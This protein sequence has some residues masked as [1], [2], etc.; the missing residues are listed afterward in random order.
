MDFTRE[1]GHQP[2]GFLR[3]A[4]IASE[5]IRSGNLATVALLDVKIAFVGDIVGEPGRR[6]VQHLVPRLRKERGVNCVIANGEN[7][8]GGAG[9][10][11]ETAAEIFSSGVDVI[12]TGDHVWDQKETA[13]FIQHEARLLRPCNYPSGTPGNGSIA[14]RLEDG[15][16]VGV[17]NLQ[18]LTFMPDLGDPFEVI[19]EE[20]RRL[21]H[22]TSILIIDFHAEATSEK[23]ALGR[24]LDGKA[25]AVLGTHTHVQTADE[26]IFPGGTAF[27]CDVG[28]T[29]P[30]DSVIGRE[31]EPVI[32]RFR[33]R[34]PQ[35]FGVARG[36]V[37]MQGV[38]LEVDPES[39]RTV[40][41]ERFSIPL[42]S[43]EA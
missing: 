43:A 23:I 19:E 7:S 22:Y 32:R 15:R 13:S 42:D 17:V 4:T 12:T 3:S 31:I 38:L 36:N 16:V 29:G 37:Q 26:R 27:L 6:A 40:S 11:Q 21:R 41:I 30:H 5:R 24:F 35:R 39:G 18:G 33:T 28:F 25:S 8:A 14:H 9:I 10:T 34:M 2:S 1:L 20:L